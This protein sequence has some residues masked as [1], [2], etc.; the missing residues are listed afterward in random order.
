[1]FDMSEAS[2]RLGAVNRARELVDEAITV[3]SD[4]GVR[5]VEVVKAMV[6]CLKAL[7]DYRH[8]THYAINKRREREKEHNNRCRQSAS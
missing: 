1:M 7:T 2:S 6:M 3:L 8:T 4:A 5:N